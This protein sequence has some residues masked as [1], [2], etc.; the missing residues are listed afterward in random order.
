MIRPVLIVVLVIFTLGVYFV[1]APPAIEDMGSTVES[2]QAVQESGMA[3]VPST[4]RTVLF[5]GVPL[6]MIGG[7]GVWALL[8]LTRRERITDQRGGLR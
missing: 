1:A 2:N 3:D 5:V 7:F 8:R 4:I 6:M